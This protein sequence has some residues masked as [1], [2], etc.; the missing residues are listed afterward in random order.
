MP[1]DGTTTQPDATLTTEKAG[2]PQFTQEQLDK[3]VRDARTA[4]L[5]DAG[6]MRTEAEKALKAAQGAQ[7]RLTKLEKERIDMELERAKDQPAEIRR[8]RAE[9]KAKELESKLEQA[10]T[11]LTE[12]KSK[13]TEYTQK[14]AESKK[15]TV[16]QEV[17]ARLNVDSATLGRLARFTDGS[18]EAIE[19]IAK[20][21]PKKTNTPEMKVDS[22]KTSGGTTQNKYQIMQD[23][24]S[25]KINAEQYAEKLKAIGEKP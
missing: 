21:L 11:E 2:T 20:T 7:E 1:T 3:A 6:R 23:F 15:Q 25:G 14:E 9:Q 22:G 19:D 16:A 12:H 5:A 18:A 4:V 10:E 24:N 17:A 13:L 8:I